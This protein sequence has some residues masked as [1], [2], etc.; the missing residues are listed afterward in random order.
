[1]LEL[2]RSLLDPMCS[3]PS[4]A[5][6]NVCQIESNAVDV[7]RGP[8][9]RSGRLR[10]ASEEADQAQN[11]AKRMYD[12]NDRNRDARGNKSGLDRARTSHDVERGRVHCRVSEVLRL[13]QSPEN[14]TML[15]PKSFRL[16]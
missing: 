1:M 3:R 4:S 7:A 6:T 9:W 5:A 10:E 11:G 14:D 8:L 13:L 12:G 15:T 2:G 16:R